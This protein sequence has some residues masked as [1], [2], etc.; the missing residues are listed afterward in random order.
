MLTRMWNLRNAHL[1]LVEM[2]N[3]AATLEG[4]LTVSYKTKILFPF[5]PAIMLGIYP[6]E[7]NIYAHTKTCTQM[8]IAALL[9]IAKTWKQPRCPLVGERVRQL[10]S[11]QTMDY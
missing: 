6:K 5:N 8:F 11:I 9:I 3:G 2:Q 7:L 1:L 10:W 4:S